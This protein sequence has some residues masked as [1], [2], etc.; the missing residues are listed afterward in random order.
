FA[1]APAA[2]A[3]TRG[4][5]HVFEQANSHYLALIGGREV[6]G[7]PFHVALPEVAG[8]PVHRLLD[9][10]YRSA[11]PYV[12]QSVPVFLRESRQLQ[13][14]ERFFNFVY[15][16]LLNE[17]GYSE[18]IAI[19]GFEV[20]E[21]VNAQRAAETANRTKDE[22]LA[23][24]GHELRNPLA[25]IITA[26][27]L[28]R[29]R[30]IT[31]AEKERAIIERQAKHLVALV[32][33][34]LDVS[35]VAQGKISLRKSNVEVSE[36]IAR[37]VETASPLLEEKFH[38]LDIHVP[39]T[40]LCINGDPERL[41][42]VVANLL[43]NSAK[44]TEQKGHIRVDA[45]WEDGSG[46]GSAEGQGDSGNVRISVTDNGIGIAQEMLPNVFD[47]FVQERQALNRSRGGLG[48][49]LAIAK[50]MV[51]LHEGSITAESGGL[52]MGSSFHVCLPL[53][54][55][56][57]QAQTPADKPLME[58][59]LP[60][61]TGSTL[62]ILIV[63]DNEDAARLLNETLT[64]LRYRTEV[65]YDGPSAVRVAESFHPDVALLDIGLPGMDGYELASR[66][67]EQANEQG[68]GKLLRLVAITGYGQEGDR[69][70][71]L[72]AGFDEHIVKP[73]DPAR[74]EG[75]LKKI[76]AAILQ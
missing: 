34:L 61:D 27:Q 4:P 31:V 25:P 12:G 41:A 9:D 45:V 67:R 7:L 60:H 51:K 47:M 52:G 73:V 74:L 70:R 22:F 53:S 68:N 29:L 8:K 54:S 36:I 11:E 5:E 66:L 40:G 35:R 39:A 17:E 69:Q 32:D 16:P 28:M 37:A 63:D 75:L 42:Q 14:E 65:A 38:V 15:Q 10:V 56:G 19:V 64:L 76:A 1:Q 21:L 18:G 57:T 71:S 33:D 23:M 30:G 26:I 62:S 2:I 50:S 6:I 43:T 58:A 3:I 46:S 44:Y 13:L 72:Q 49:G 55:C 20:T 24:L 48:L 59:E